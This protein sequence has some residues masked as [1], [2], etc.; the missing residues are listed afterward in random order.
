MTVTCPQC[1][2][3]G[4]IPPGTPL[5]KS[6]RC[7][8]C[9]TRF[10]PPPVK[11]PPQN[12]TTR[13]LICM[14]I[15]TVFALLSISIASIFA[16]VFVFRG[17][18][19]HP[20]PARAIEAKAAPRDQE[21]PLPDVTFESDLA[22]R[23]SAIAPNPDTPLL[24][25]L[26]KYRLKYVLPDWARES[27]V[28]SSGNYSGTLTHGSPFLLDDNTL[29]LIVA[30]D[31]NTFALWHLD[32]T[33]GR[34]RKVRD[35]RDATG[36]GRYHS[37]TWHRDKDGKLLGQFIQIVRDKRR[38]RS[39]YGDTMIHFGV[40]Y[41]GLL[42]PTNGEAKM[43][44]VR[45]ESD[46]GPGVLVDMLLR[47]T[48][49]TNT[50]AKL[51][52]GQDALRV[53]GDRLG[54][55][56]LGFDDA[57]STIFLKPELI[58]SWRDTLGSIDV[59]EATSLARISETFTGVH[60]APDCPLT[61]ELGTT[62]RFAIASAKEDQKELTALSRTQSKKYLRNF[63]AYEL[64]HLIALKSDRIQD[65]VDF[66][67]QDPGTP[68]RDLAKLRVHEIAYAS[69]CKTAT[70]DTFDKFMQVFPDSIQWK[71]AFEHSCDLELERAR[72]QIERASD[73]DRKREQIANSFY[74]RWRDCQREGQYPTAERLW[75]LMKD[76]ADFNVTQAAKEAQ[77]AKDRDI[78]QE[79][80]IEL[81]EERNRTLTR[82]E[83]VQRKQLT[84]MLEANEV[85]HQQLAATQ[86]GNKLRQEGNDLMRE[87]NAV[88]GT[89]ADNVNT[90]KNNGK[91]FAKK[92]GISL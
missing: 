28:I 75:N 26:R 50:Q 11:A 9:Q 12:A 18:P 84:A 91:T 29:V 60:N 70:I 59:T 32:L 64:L 77:D 48:L 36:G 15:G 33:S 4:N 24:D 69:A 27:A 80:I 53:A 22:K 45:G 31:E 62:L 79:K 89:I 44:S 67:Q 68:A 88:L 66:V 39:L 92:F 73:H 56:G 42:D 83:D 3:H 41:I 47:S 37:V 74:T 71:K 78:F 5:G 61:Q 25:S 16:I 21:K 87:G 51:T 40:A 54:H 58:Q 55:S 46:V 7:S 57:Q 76:E 85:A 20:E 49:P 19:A 90:I 23:I 6:I 52:T 34:L 1:G 17:V 43:N 2:A 86:E 38:K 81:N 63:A 30:T 65:Y 82:I 8:R 14:F 35:Y 72:F 10:Q 13:T